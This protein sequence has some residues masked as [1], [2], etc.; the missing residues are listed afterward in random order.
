MNRTHNIR[1]PKYSTNVQKM[2]NGK[3]VL[4]SQIRA[5]LKSCQIQYGLWP[6]MILALQKEFN[7]PSSK[8]APGNRMAWTFALH[9]YIA[10]LSW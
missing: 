4:G 2:M 6:M 7:M 9:Q 1:I 10:S 3:V 5:T 8:S